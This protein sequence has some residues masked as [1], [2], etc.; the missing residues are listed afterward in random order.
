MRK[1][2]LQ[3]VAP[4]QELY[5]R[6]TNL[7]VAGFIGSPAMNFAQ[8]TIEGDGSG[9][10][11]TIGSERLEI[12]DDETARHP[13]LAEHSG[14]NFIVGIRP[15]HLEDLAF[16][17][18][19]PAGRRLNGLVR[20]KEALGSEMV[21]HFQIE[22]APAVLPEL[23]ELTED[24]DET[25]LLQDIDAFDQDRR[26]RRT[27]FVGRF[28]VGTRVEEDAAAAIAVAP[29]ALRFFDAK[30]GQAIGTPAASFGS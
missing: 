10:S 12:D 20:L 9:L 13:G 7:F 30:T 25:T 29:A 16:A 4:P 28:G 22:A 21:V 27:A 2:E 19:T 24:M 14:S 6:P 1:G 3:Q 5:D 8:G 26:I 15:E 17:S 18:D 23:Q 11:V